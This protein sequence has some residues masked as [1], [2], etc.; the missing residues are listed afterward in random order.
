MQ[1]IH[2][3]HIQLKHP[4]WNSKNTYLHETLEI[5]I[6]VKMISGI[7]KTLKIEID[8]NKYPK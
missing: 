4:Q 7:H 2:N 5:E 3:I 8:V 1:Q 6:N